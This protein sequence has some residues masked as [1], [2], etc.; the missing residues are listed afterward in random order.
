MTILGIDIGT[1]SIKVTHIE[2]GKKV[3][4]LQSETIAYNDKHIASHDPQ[5]WWKK[6]QKILQKVKNKERIEAVGMTGQMHSLIMLDSDGNIIQPV[7][8]WFDKD[9]HKQL[10]DFIQAIPH[11][12]DRMGNLPLADFTLAKWLLATSKDNM[13]PSKVSK[14]L[15][16]KDYIR[17]QMDPKAAYIVDYNEAAGMQLLHPFSSNW[18]KEICHKAH[19][20]VEKLPQIVKAQTIGGYTSAIEGIKDNI[21]IIVGS[22]DQAAAARA[23]G[24]FEEGTASLSLGTSGVISIPVKRANFSMD[25]FKGFHLF[26]MGFDDIYQI[27]GTIPALGETLL[28]L[29]QFLDKD[30]GEIDKIARTY[31]QNVSCFFLPYLSGKGSPYPDNQISASVQNLTLKNTGEDFIQSVYNSL[32]LEFKKT[33]DHIQNRN[34]NINK[35]VVSGGASAFP[36]LLM[37]IKTYLD[38]KLTL[39]NSP[40]ASAVGAALFAYDNL[41]PG[42]R[43]FLEQKEL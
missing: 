2:V 3:T 11:F 28:W 31:N 7:K 25:A 41:H 39:A 8:L 34:I 1:S 32:A 16:A 17:L 21:P 37:R 33:I 5:L 23:T 27:I 42:H 12:H 40:D 35:V 22:G 20:E 10:Q 36:A 9:G 18:D 13:L 30:L 14:I 29:A 19:I 24:A 38:V 26:P 4:I 15:C 43:V 6:L